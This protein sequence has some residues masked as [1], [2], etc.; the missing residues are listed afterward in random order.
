MD[1]CGFHDSAEPIDCSRALCAW[2]TASAEALEPSAVAAAE[3]KSASDSCARSHRAQP[4]AATGAEPCSSAHSAHDT[5]L[6][7]TALCAESDE[8]WLFTCA[9]T[10][11]PRAVLRAL[12]LSATCLVLNADASSWR[13]LDDIVAALLPRLRNTAASRMA[14]KRS[15]SHALQSVVASLF[16]HPEVVLWITGASQRSRPTLAAFAQ[17]LQA[18]Y[19]AQADPGC[20]CMI[21]TIDDHWD[22]LVGAS[23]HDGATEVVMRITRIELGR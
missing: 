22:A 7:T 21:L 8:L 9:T 17:L 12:G 23:T 19:D 4:P 2:R 20:V 5:T 16:L 3:P 10:T 15:D 14:M 18:G 6:N 1:E 11:R 13:S